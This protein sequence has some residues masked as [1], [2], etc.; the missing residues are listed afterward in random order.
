MLKETR[1]ILHA[2]IALIVTLSPGE[3]KDPGLHGYTFGVGLA[4]TLTELVNVLGVDE[5]RPV[6]V[7]F[8]FTM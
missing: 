5:R 1:C 2:G 3:S 6:T 7:R 8:R 4:T